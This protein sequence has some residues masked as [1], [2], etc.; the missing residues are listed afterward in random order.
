MLNRFETMLRGSLISLIMT[1]T[2][3]LDSFNTSGTSTLT[4]ITADVGK[5]CDTYKSL[6]NI[7]SDPTSIGVALW[8]LER[9][10]GIGFI[11]PAIPGLSKLMR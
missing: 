5:I 7:W 1:Q 11:G 2:L 9:Q 8:L 4:L 6:N 10:L 3:E